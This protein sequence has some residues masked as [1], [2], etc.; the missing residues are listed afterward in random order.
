MFLVFY[1]YHSNA[2]TGMYGQD[3]FE[4]DGEKYNI[5]LAIYYAASVYCRRQF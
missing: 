3:A 4:P 1:Q 2:R 5:W